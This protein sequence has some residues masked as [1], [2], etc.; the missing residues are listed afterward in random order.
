[1]RRSPLKRKSK[2][3]TAKAREE[4]Q[5]LVREIVIARDG[6]CLLRDPPGLPPC[7]GYRADGE[8]VL[9]ADHLITRGK[10]IGF[11]DTRLICC[12]CKGHHTAK[13]FDQND[14]Y[15]PIIREKIGP[16]RAELWAK[17]KADRR[18]YPMGLWEW[19]KEILALKKELATHEE[20]MLQ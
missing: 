2:S 9:Q 1:M 7:N 15:E 6:G 4:I 12:L 5:R 8:L 14:T 10:N 19:Q 18:S 13:T 17:C 3:E 16:E 11:A 20:H